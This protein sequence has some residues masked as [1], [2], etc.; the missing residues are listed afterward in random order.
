MSESTPPP[1][2]HGPAGQSPQT[3]FARLFDVRFSSYVTPTIIP[4]LYVL[5]MV[6]IVLA[7]LFYVVAGFNISTGLG[8]L[9]LL[10]IGP[11]FALLA[12]VWLRVT[13]EFYLALIRLSGDFREWREEWRSRS[14]I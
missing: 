10:I 8:V 14:H 4:V 2:P 13:L 6:G 7:Y 3:F 12:L 1:A 9:T 5:G 11:L